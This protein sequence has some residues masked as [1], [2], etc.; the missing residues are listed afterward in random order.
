[1]IFDPS[2]QISWFG[3]ASLASI[4]IVANTVYIVF[5]WFSYQDDYSEVEKSFQQIEPHSFVLIGQVTDSS[6]IGIL[7]T[8][9]GPIVSAPTLAVYYAKAFVPN[10]FTFPGE[11][12]VE[13]RPEYKQFAITNIGHYQIPVDVLTAT[14]NGTPFRNAEFL[15]NW[16][17]HFDYVYI[18]GPHIPN[19][20]PHRLTQ[21]IA[22][23]RFTL[24]RIIK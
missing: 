8:T 15:Q 9:Y 16:P 10:L 11:Q 17:Q 6:L 14:A 22:A 5:V 21:I 12:P 19:P 13:V 3:A 7:D 23:R 20:L 4:A 24:Y 1:L 18:V 2:R